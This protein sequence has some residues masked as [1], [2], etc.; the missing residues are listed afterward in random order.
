MSTTRAGPPVS[1]STSSSSTWIGHPAGGASRTRWPRRTSRLFDPQDGAGAEPLTIVVT[2]QDQVELDLTDHAAL[3][4]AQ[5]RVP[6]PTGEKLAA[7]VR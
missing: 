1:S 7:E 5:A 3:A 4:R 2:E 6:D